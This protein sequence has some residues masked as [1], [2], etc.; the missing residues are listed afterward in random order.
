MKSFSKY[1]P[2]LL[3]CA[4]AIASFSIAQSA[5]A[6][7]APAPAKAPANATVA[8]AASPVARSQA[9]GGSQ[10]QA[11]SSTLAIGTGDELQVKVYGAPDLSVLTRVASD[12]TISLPLVGYVPVAGL[13]SDQ[14]Q[15]E[16]SNRLRDRHIVKDPQVFVFVKEYTNSEISVVGEVVKPGVFSALGPHRLLDVLEEAGG[17]TEKASNSISV[18]HRGSDQV[19]TLRLSNDAAEMARNNIELQPGDTVLVPK[20][21]IV[22]VLGEVYKPGGY[23]LNSTG[24]ITVLQVVSAAGGPTR[25]ASI[26]GTKMVRRTP[27]GLKEVPVPLKELLNAKVDDMRVQP[28]DIL[29][30]PSSRM[31]SALSMG[32]LLSNAGA[33]AVYRIP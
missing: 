33:A 22:Y 20:A 7:A 9:E 1:H 23:A 6:Q 27:T 3:V 8:Q 4:L 25:L 12:G 21:G 26:S 11:A 29:Y 16:I 31:K 28:G 5:R 10:S 14:A 32:T 19:T 24:G 13:T 15:E 2:Q 30:I 17:P 18:S